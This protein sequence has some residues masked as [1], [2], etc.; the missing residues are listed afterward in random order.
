MITDKFILGFVHAVKTKI[1]ER[2][3]DVARAKIENL[4]DHARL[5]GSIDGLEEALNVLDEVIEDLDK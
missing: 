5:Q 2:E 4:Y 1:S 3:K